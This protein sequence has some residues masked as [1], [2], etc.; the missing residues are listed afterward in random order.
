MSLDNNITTDRADEP[1]T[2]ADIEQRIQNVGS[3]NRLD[4]SGQNLEGIDLSG[5]DLRGANL[6]E[7]NLRGANLSEANLSEANLRGANL[8][9]ALQLHLFGESL[10]EGAFGEKLF[11]L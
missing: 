6:S 11:S 10:P 3:S 9:S 2:R 8:L 4:V 1:L 5:T 7:A